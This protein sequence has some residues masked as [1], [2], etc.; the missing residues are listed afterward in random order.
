MYLAITQRIRAHS[1]LSAYTAQ[2][3]AGFAPDTRYPSNDKLGIGT[4]LH[5][6]NL[7]NRG[8]RTQTSNGSVT[9]TGKAHLDLYDPDTGLAGMAGHGVIDGLIGH[10]ADLLRSNIDPASCPW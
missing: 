7:L 5:L 6:E 9:L 8:N 10:I 4:T 2:G 3:E 1:F